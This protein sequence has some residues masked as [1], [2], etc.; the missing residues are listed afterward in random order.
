MRCR[1]I[2]CVV[3]V[4]CLMF[5][6]SCQTGGRSAAGSV[7]SDVKAAAKERTIE[8]E[9]L[10]DAGALAAAYDAEA[11]DSDAALLLFMNALLLIEEDKDAGYAAAAYM[12]RKADQW[13]DANG[14]T[15]VKPSKAASEGHRRIWER[16]EI[17]RSYCGGSG[18]SYT[19]S[20][21]G[22]VKLRIKETRDESNGVKYFIWSS[23]KDNAS[24]IMLK[25][26]GGRWHVDE[27]SSIQTGVKKQ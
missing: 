2:A 21:P 4:S 14:P 3:A 10:H 1:A 27:W 16:P 18:S 26:S 6:A 15:G 9:R 23:G 13:E 7:K 17:A 22:K 24:P 12:M 8:R 25:S 11:G 19:M 5:A 20:T